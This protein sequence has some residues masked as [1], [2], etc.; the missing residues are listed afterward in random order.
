MLLPIADCQVPIYINW[1]SAIGNW[2]STK[3]HKKDKRFYGKP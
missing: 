1:Q 2:Q 3:T